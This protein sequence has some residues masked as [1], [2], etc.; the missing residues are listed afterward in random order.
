MESLPLPVTVPTTQPPPSSAGIT[1]TNSPDSLP[2]A[3]LVIIGSAA[4]DITAQALPTTSPAR[5]LHSTSPGTVSLSLGG[6][7]R[8]VAEAAHRVLSSWSS[9]FE[10]GSKPE[11]REESPATVLVSAVGKDSFGRLLVDEMGR[12]GMRTDGLLCGSEETGRSAVCNMVLDG[13]GGLVGGVADM[14]IILSLKEKEVFAALS[15]HGP[16]LKAE[17]GADLFILHTSAC[18]VSRFWISYGN[19]GLQ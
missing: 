15:F 10:A 9:K 4:I 5:G 12:M 8:N 7:G 11:A 6:V 19:I 2:P 1:A 16:V 17:W 14:D 13:K 18:H 3:K